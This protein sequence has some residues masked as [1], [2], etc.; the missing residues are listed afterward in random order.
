M[1]CGGG[2]GDASERPIELRH[3]PARGGG[4]KY[5][6]VDITLSG[7]S[8]DEGA[9]ECQLGNRNEARVGEEGTWWVLPRAHS[10]RFFSGRGFG[11]C[12]FVLIGTY[13]PSNVLAY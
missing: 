7:R 9:G 11:M 1:F 5:A 10:V 13:T 4:L 12:N 8:K 3:G 2:V 6:D